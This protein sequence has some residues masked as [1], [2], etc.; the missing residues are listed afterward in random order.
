MEFVHLI[1]LLALVEYI[2]FIAIVGAG[3]GKYNVEAPATTGDPRWE[4]L[5]RVQANTAEQLI[6]FV[7]GMYA[8][9]HYVSPLWA[10]IIGCVFVVG[11]LIYYTGYKQEGDKRGPGVLMSIPPNIVL[12]VGAL[13]GLLMGLF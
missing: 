9:A 7:P 6:L 12:V 3:R 13:I 4:R 2:F 10:A 5:Y 11:R 8:F 1:I